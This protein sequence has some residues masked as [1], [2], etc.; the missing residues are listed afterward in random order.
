MLII[1][2]DFHT[3]GGRLVDPLNALKLSWVPL[4]FGFWFIKGCVF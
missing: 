3:A 4:P 1:G 2:C